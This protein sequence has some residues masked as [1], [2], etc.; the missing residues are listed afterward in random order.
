MKDVFSKY[1]W[2]KPLKDKKVKRFFNDFIGIINES[3][4][5]TNKLWA[6]QWK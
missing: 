4:R 1:V 6:D 5:K 3:K 2:F